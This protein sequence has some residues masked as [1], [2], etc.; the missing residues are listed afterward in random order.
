[1][2]KI[3]EVHICFFVYLAMEEGGNGEV[4]CS[5]CG[6]HQAKEGPNSVVVEGWDE[7]CSCTACTKDICPGSLVQPIIY[8]VYVAVTRQTCRHWIK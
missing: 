7:D 2:D 5:V 1:M 3:L 4:P 6:H 8:V